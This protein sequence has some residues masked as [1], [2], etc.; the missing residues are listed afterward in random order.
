MSDWAFKATR[1]I[2]FAILAPT[3]I[4]ILMLNSEPVNAST[5]AA[6]VEASV[7]W[8]Y[9]L[10]KCVWTSEVADV[11]TRMKAFGMTKKAV[12]SWPGISGKAAVVSIINE[13]YYNDVQPIDLFLRC[14]ESIK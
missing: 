13:V 1:D 9:P 4:A 11:V 6:P 5:Y 14:S 3:I 7:T 8:E 10:Q 2:L 12:L